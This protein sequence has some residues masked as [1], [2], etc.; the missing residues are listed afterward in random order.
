MHSRV[1]TWRDFIFLR[2]LREHHARA[3]APAGD[4]E[5]WTQDS[6]NSSV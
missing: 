4:I 5:A 2:E 6:R 1:Y 3:R